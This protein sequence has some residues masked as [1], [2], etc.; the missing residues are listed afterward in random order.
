MLAIKG[1]YKRV[2]IANS[3]AN[4]S[5]F[6]F[7]KDALFFGEWSRLNAKNLSFILYC[8]EAAS[9]LEINLAKSRLFS[10]GVAIKDVNVV[11]SSLG[12]SH[13]VPPF[14][15]LG[16]PIDKKALWRLVIKEFMA[17]MEVF[18]LIRINLRVEVFG[19]TFSGL[20]QIMKVNYKISF[21]MEASNG[22][23]EAYVLA[24]GK[25]FEEKHMT[26]ARFGKKLDKTQHLVSQSVETVSGFATT[27]SEVK[28]HGVTTTCDAV[29]ITDIK[30][31]LEYS[32][33]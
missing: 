18:V 7:A 6:Q 14:S 22:S 24:F 27:P 30:K 12:C 26:W 11:A 19:A 2:S 23:L 1:I 25:H 5:L 31:P 10:I 20:P 32:A 3:G 9:S 15:Y 28:G 4:I 8:F 29:T 13:D 33:G 17:I 16:L 21:N